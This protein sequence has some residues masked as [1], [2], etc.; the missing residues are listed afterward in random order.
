MLEAF[1]VR[2]ACSGTSAGIQGPATLTASRIEVPGDFSSA[3]FFIVAGLIAGSGP[4]RIR[5]V[6][7][8]PTRTALIDILRLMGADIRLHGADDCRR[9]NRAP[10]SKSGPSRLRGIVVPPAL[11]P[12]RPRRVADP[13][14][15]GSRRRGR[16]GRDRRR[17]TARQGERPPGR[18]GGRTRVDRALQSMRLPDGL[19]IHGGACLW[20]CRREP[21][22]PS[23][24]DVFRRAGRPGSLADRHPRRAECRDLV[25]RIRRRR[26]GRRDCQLAEAG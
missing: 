4:L 22:R 26:R 5:D 7:V 21:W 19:R 6:G 20:R 17:R 10:I 1:G 14:C 18:H 24:R 16:H 2:V 3:A 8:N 15:R 13:L 12:M 11:V 23:G 25:P 9:A